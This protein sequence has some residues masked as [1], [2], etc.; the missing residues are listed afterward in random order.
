MSSL[1]LS[2]NQEPDCISCN[3]YYGHDI[4]SNTNGKYCS[5]CFFRAYPEES[6]DIIEKYGMFENN[7]TP[8]ELNDYIRKY[9]VSEN[10]PY[11]KGIKL[12]LKDKI[13]YNNVRI[14]AIKEIFK[15]LKKLGKMNVGITA[16]QGAFIWYNL[17]PLERKQ[18]NDGWKLQHLICGCIIDY[19]NIK[20]QD[21][22]IGH[23]YYGNFG[24]KPIKSVPIL[25]PAMILSYQSN[26]SNKEKH[27]LDF[28]KENLP[29]KNEVEE[30]LQNQF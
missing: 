23:C 21:G 28:W 5:K 7:Y 6:K 20:V 11:W 22:N 19:W 2:N 29:F 27:K 3:K 18:F 26:L 24:A 10:N 15:I 14:V 16:E 8:E 30:E 25:F 4:F 9:S 17:K 1:V 13:M 12:I